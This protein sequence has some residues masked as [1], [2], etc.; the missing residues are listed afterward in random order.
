MAVSKKRKKVLFLVVALLIILISLFLFG[1]YMLRRNSEQI[2]GLLKN[3]VSS[4]VI[5]REE[6]L[7]QVI[8]EISSQEVPKYVSLRMKTED[9]ILLKELDNDKVTKVFR[10]FSLVLISN[11]LDNSEGGYVAFAI[12]PDVTGLVWDGY[13]HGFYY[14]EEDSPIDIFTGDNVDCNTKVYGELMPSMP[15]MPSNKDW[16]RT[17]KITDNWWYYEAHFIWK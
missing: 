5:K 1:V 9:T 13:T 7:I 11:N 3:K 6:E 17:E 12:S 16:Y 14:S 10:E 2:Q 15:S 8:A 4:D